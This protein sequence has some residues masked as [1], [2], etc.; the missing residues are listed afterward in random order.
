MHFFSPSHIVAVKLGEIISSCIKEQKVRYKPCLGAKCSD[1][2]S[3]V[4]LLETPWYWLN[5]KWEETKCVGKSALH[6]FLRSF[7]KALDELVTKRCWMTHPCVSKGRT[8]ALSAVI[9]SLLCN[10]TSP[11]SQTGSCSITA[12][13]GT[14]ALL[15]RW[16]LLESVAYYMILAIVYVTGGYCC[17]QS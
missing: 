15:T 16:F 10:T 3:S 13:G 12:V 2:L 4:H 17:Q 8:E 9:V 1:R 5:K 7:E 6:I 11:S 14:R